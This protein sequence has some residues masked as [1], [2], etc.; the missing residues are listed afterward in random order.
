MPYPKHKLRW[1]KQNHIKDLW[2]FPLVER[3]GAALIDNIVVI[4]IWLAAHYTILNPYHSE[5]FNRLNIH[6][7]N[8]F[9]VLLIIHVLYFTLIQ[10]VAQTTVGKRCYSLSV[11]LMNGKRV[12]LF[13]MII[14]YPFSLTFNLLVFSRLALMIDGILPVA[15]DDKNQKVYLFQDVLSNT[16]VLTKEEFEKI[17]TIKP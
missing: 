11:S 16:C 14:R 7:F 12:N 9:Y 1:T 2:K 4:I 13:A 17:K 15:Y 5:I 8:T 10:T 6:T 3:A